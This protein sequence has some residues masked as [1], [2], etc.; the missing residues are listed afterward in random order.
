MKKY[1][2]RSM[3]MLS[4]CIGMMLGCKKDDEFGVNPA[5]TDLQKSLEDPRPVEGNVRFFITDPKLEL[6]IIQRVP[7]FKMDILVFGKKDSEG[8]I[9]D[10]T[11]TIISNPN[12]E[13]WVETHYEKGYPVQYETSTG[14]IVE[15]K[16]YNKGKSS[17]AGTIR[18]KSDNTI[19]KEFADYQLSSE[20]FQNIDAYSKL[21][22]ARVAAIN[23]ICNDNTARAVSAAAVAANTFG[24]VLGITEIVVTGGLAA[25]PMGV[26]TLLNC[27][28]AVSGLY[29]AFTKD[30]IEDNY[31]GPL[32]VCAASG[33]GDGYQLYYE[34]LKTP[35]NLPGF[36]LKCAANLIAA[37]ADNYECGCKDNSPEKDPAHSTADPHLMTLDGLNYDFQGRGEF[38]VVKST[39]DN[40][41]I[42]SRQDDILNNGRATF[43]TAIAVQT[44]TDVV[45]FTANPTRLFI[46][47]QSQ[48]FASLTSLSLKDGASISKE[49]S[50]TLNII[51][52]NGDLVKVV[53][54]GSGYLDYY[55]YLAEN[56]KG[57]VIGLLGNY[58]GNKG[59]DV[60]VRNGENI[61]QNGSI[62]FDKLYSTFADSWRIS[63]SNSLFYYD[64]G[65][66]TDSFTEKNFPRTIAILTAA[67]RTSAEATCRAAGV[68]AEPFLSNCIF[69]VAITNNPAM[70]ASALYGQNADSRIILPVPIV[71]EAVDVKTINSLR[72]SSFVLKR[73]GTLW[74]SGI[75]NY[76][77]FGVGQ[78]SKF[79]TNN[80]F[81]KIMEGIKEIAKGDG[82]HMLFLKNDNSVWAAGLNQFGQVGNGTASNDG[83]LTAVKIMTDAKDLFVGQL[84]SFVLKNDNT[85]WAF[86]RN[87]GGQLGN[88]SSYSLAQTTPVKI[89]N[90]VKSVSIGYSNALVLKTDNSLWAFGDNSDG[91]FGF[92]KD[93]KPSSNLPIKIMDNVKGIAAGYGNS[94]VIKQDNT[95]W[96]S[97]R[98]L[99][100][101]L[102]NGTT[103]STSEF[104]KIMDNVTTVAINYYNTL[105]LKEDNTLWGTGSNAGATLGIG[106]TNDTSKP[107]QIATDVSYIAMGW[108][109][110]F[111]VKKDNTLWVSGSNNSGELGSGTY[112]GNIPY[113]SRSFFQINVK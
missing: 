67:Q 58:D 34:C 52:K 31:L 26:G 32:G 60:V 73:D 30:D 45:C 86:G 101:V 50:N 17:V 99:N 56:R 77:E 70:T 64:S 82:N 108:G 103:A 110:A 68:S 83:V 61:L 29:E 113:G 104:K 91:A 38:I 27:Y 35:S 79:S 81:I 22:S 36:I 72:S 55:L 12:T 39:T 54:Q 21:K 71:F 69:D 96:G 5:I 105:I 112:N 15:L 88:G 62:P 111:I 49:G 89:M 84:N 93:V 76:G 78:A 87:Y 10:V 85:L 24:C 14:F 42:Q 102:G 53:V 66:T 6:G 80:K 25:I 33:A 44:G 19:V 48:N 1:V 23:G 98:N 57:K 9:T 92:S 109:G 4:L 43:N 51:T 11:K 59:N 46:N 63:Q 16:N 2:Y 90:D 8:Y 41:E 37:E 7:S 20:F 97:G 18:K 95:L 65:K 47:K 75:N 100:G 40:F 106:I 74:V 94:L 107:I 13:G 3:I 28:G